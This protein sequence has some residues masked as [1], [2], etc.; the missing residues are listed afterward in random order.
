M[1]KTRNVQNFQDSVLHTS[2]F[3]TYA[4][5]LLHKLRPLQRPQL[6]VAGQ[7][8]HRRKDLGHDSQMLQE[9]KTAF[10]NS[11]MHNQYTRRRANEHMRPLTCII[12]T[13]D[14]TTY[15]SLGVLSEVCSSCEEVC[16]LQHQTDQPIT[17]KRQLN[18]N[19]PGISTFRMMNSKR[20]PPTK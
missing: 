6:E 15:A 12:S 13:P 14:V 10:L 20:L 17:G 3:I 4:L 19:L 11:D 16:L 18:I 7:G 2:A 1:N 8:M 9:R 5:L